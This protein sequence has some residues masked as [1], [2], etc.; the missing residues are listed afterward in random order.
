MILFLVYNV[1]FVD[2]TLNIPAHLSSFFLFFKLCRYLT[3]AVSSRL[4]VTFYPQSSIP[5]LPYSSF[6]PSAYV[7][8]QSKRKLSSQRIGGLCCRCVIMG[9]TSTSSSSP[10]YITRKRHARNILVRLLSSAFSLLPAHEQLRRYLVPPFRPLRCYHHR[11]KTSYLLASLLPPPSCP[12]ATVI[13]ST[14]IPRAILTLA[15]SPGH[16]APR[17]LRLQTPLLS[18]PLATRKGHATFPSFILPPP[19]SSRSLLRVARVLVQ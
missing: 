5:L 1:F 18:S 8:V 16:H 11:E 9:L 13:F 2:R 6:S 7:P 12:S 19:S 4:L 17:R 15:P 14:A 3:T 10:S